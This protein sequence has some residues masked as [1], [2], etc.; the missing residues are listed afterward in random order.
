MEWTEERLR[1]RERESYTSSFAVHCN[2]VVFCL[3]HSLGLLTLFLSFFQSISDHLSLISVL[4]SLSF[5]D[6]FP[7]IPS[8]PLSGGSRNKKEWSPVLTYL[9]PG[10]VRLTVC[11]HLPIFFYRG[12]SPARQTSSPLNIRSTSSPIPI[13]NIN[14]STRRIS[15]GSGGI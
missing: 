11:G 2:L 13:H 9:F 10:D 8:P 1:G 12:I 14:P 3:H 7:N 6:Y 15:P 5:I 4:F